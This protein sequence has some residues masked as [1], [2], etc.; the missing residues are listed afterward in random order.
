MKSTNCRLFVLLKFIPILF[1]FGISICPVGS[2]NLFFNEEVMKNLNPNTLELVEPTDAILNSKAEAVV[3]DEINSP[4]IQGVINRMLELSTGKGHSKHDSRQMVGLAAM[5]LGIPKRIVTIDVTAD[6]SNK[7][8]NLHVILNPVITDISEVLAPGREACWS[9]GDIC[10]NVDRSKS[11]TLEGLDRDG[12]DVA[13]K[14][15]DFVARIAQHETDHLEGIRFPDR[16]P[17]DEPTRLHIV[18]PE[19][20]PEYR[21]DW[22]T[23]PNVCPRDRWEAMK[24]GGT[25]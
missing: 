23:W 8:Q 17:L 2:N 15:E 18:K 10:G 11:V 12:K 22:A 1:G 3:S 9:C 16:I 13:Y 24:S 19:E 21:T 4:F 14:L 20:F 25:K 6:G 7:P 5:Q